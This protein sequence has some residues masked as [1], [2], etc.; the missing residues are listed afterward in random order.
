M[1]LSG[2]LTQVWRY[3]SAEYYCYCYRLE[4][5]IKNLLQDYSD[6]MDVKVTL[7]MEISAYRKLVQAEEV[8]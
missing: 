6:L 3:I 4:K 8:S 5:Q 1:F 7:D 2:Y